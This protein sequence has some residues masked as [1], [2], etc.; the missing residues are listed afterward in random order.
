MEGKDSHVARR[1]EYV[2]CDKRGRY[3]EAS[4]IEVDDEGQ[5]KDRTRESG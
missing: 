4:R 3:N 2:T 1:K 5:A